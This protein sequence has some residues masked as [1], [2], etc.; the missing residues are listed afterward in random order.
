MPSSFPP[1]T[2]SW[3]WGQGS[4]SAP[5]WHVSIRGFHTIAQWLFLLKNLMLQLRGTA[6]RIPSVGPSHSL[7]R[8]S[9]HDAG[10]VPPS[11]E[12][13]SAGTNRGLPMSD[14]TLR[15]DMHVSSRHSRYEGTSTG[16]THTYTY[17]HAHSSSY[18]LMLLLHFVHFY[19]VDTWHI[20]TFTHIT[21]T[22]T[23]I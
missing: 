22:N 14:S 9:M 17:I 19:N 18:T 4:P 2:S 8:M 1:P 11:D 15:D 6:P 7:R 16:I 12:G 3:R 23:H 20:H 5:C 13:T 21:N 10:G